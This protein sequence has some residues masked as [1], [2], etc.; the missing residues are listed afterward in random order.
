MNGDFDF[1]SYDVDKMFGLLAK[2]NPMVLEWI[3]SHIVYMNKLP[4]WKNFQQD[5]LANINFS[6]LFFHYLSLARGHIKIMET[7]KKFTYKIYFIVFVD[8]YQLILQRSK[9]YQ[10]F[11]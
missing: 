3:R 2:S 7:N 11:Q 1:V 9:F 5:I 6:A 8:C 4:S 10:S